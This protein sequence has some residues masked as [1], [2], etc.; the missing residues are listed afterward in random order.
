[1][2]ERIEIARNNRT[3]GFARTGAAGASMMSAGAGA[4]FRVSPRH[5]D[6]SF[7]TNRGHR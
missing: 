5:D 3:N 1:M 2:M 6:A 4:R 7:L